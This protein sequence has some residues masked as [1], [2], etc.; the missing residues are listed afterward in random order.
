MTI[1]DR[2]KTR[3]IMQFC[4]HLIEYYP[5]PFKDRFAGEILTAIQDSLAASP[6]ESQPRVSAFNLAAD[7][8]PSI[9]YEYFAEWR[10]SMKIASVIQKVAIAALAAWA[11]IWAWFITSW[12]GLLDMADPQKWLLGNGYSVANDILGAGLY[13]VPFLTLLAFLVPSLKVQVQMESGDSVL[14]VRLTKMS[15]PQ[16]GIS[17]VCL[18]A[19]LLLWGMVFTARMGWW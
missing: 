11:V 13:L 7:L 10:C 19:T 17:L 12:T 2:Y 8:I 16:A 14:M 18:T 9:I 3:R 15:K 1:E 5:Q 4:E 6:H